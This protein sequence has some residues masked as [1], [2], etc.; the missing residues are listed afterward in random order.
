MN[1]IIIG[2][3]NDSE[4][5]TT[6]GTSE[7]EAHTHDTTESNS[8]DGRELQTRQVLMIVI[9]Q[10]DQRPLHLSMVPINPNYDFQLLF[11]EV[12]YVAFRSHGMGS[13]PG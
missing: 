8:G 11:K 3:T 5:P 10:M 12:D 1:L 13:F 2:N 4:E 6:H 7:K 9:Q